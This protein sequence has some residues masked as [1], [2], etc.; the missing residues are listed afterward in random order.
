MFEDD[1]TTTT[2]RFAIIAATILGAAWLTI[3]AVQAHRTARAE[4]EAIEA[5]NALA[6]PPGTANFHVKPLPASL[7]PDAPKQAYRFKDAGGAWHI[8]DRLPPDGTAFEV[9]PLK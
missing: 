9:I 6:L 5:I 7:Q 3:Y 8:T 2:L 4:K 1:S